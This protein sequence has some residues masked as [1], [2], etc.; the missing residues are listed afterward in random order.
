[1]QNPTITLATINSKVSPPISP[2]MPPPK[3]KMYQLLQQY[4]YGQIAKVG[5][6]SR[7]IGGSQ[8]PPPPG[9]S[10][11]D[12]GIC[13]DSD[14]QLSPRHINNAGIFGNKSKKLQHKFELPIYHKHLTPKSAWYDLKPRESLL[15]AASHAPELR[16]P[17]PPNCPRN[18]CSYLTV[19]LNFSS[20]SN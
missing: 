17:L 2:P 9:D 3:P 16:P 4:Q 18:C 13:A 19:E 8:L 12:S 11:T 10:D 7:N 20:S 14:S 5:Q 15:S 6:L 1:M